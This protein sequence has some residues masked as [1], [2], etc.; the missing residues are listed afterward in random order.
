M[1]VLVLNKAGVLSGC[2]SALWER[3][4]VLCAGAS[5]RIDVAS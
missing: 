4:F 5:V 3:N 2:C 1:C